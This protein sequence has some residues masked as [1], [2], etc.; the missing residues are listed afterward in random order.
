MNH[1]A[2]C[3]PAPTRLFLLFTIL[4]CF[5][6][7]LYLAVETADANSDC[8]LDAGIIQPMQGT[9]WMEE[10][11]VRAAWLENPGASGKEHPTPVLQKTAY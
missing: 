5:T 7:A 6:A 4:S 9:G 1:A 10:E 2:H 3:G 8:Y 11:G